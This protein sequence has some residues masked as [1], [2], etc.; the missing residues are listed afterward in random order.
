MTQATA[1]QQDTKEHTFRIK[2]LILARL[3]VEFPLHDVADLG[4]VVQR[5]WNDIETD[6]EAVEKKRIVGV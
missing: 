3:R 5:M 1:A 2:Q 4:M 6:T